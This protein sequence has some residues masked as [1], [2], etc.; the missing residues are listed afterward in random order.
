MDNR[1]I[2]DIGSIISDINLGTA[3]KFGRVFHEKI[4]TQGEEEEHIPQMDMCEDKGPIGDY[5]ST[6]RELSLL[7]DNIK[8]KW[9]I[10]NNTEVD[11]FNTYYQRDLLY[12]YDRISLDMDY[13]NG[14]PERNNG[15]L[16]KL[17]ELKYEIRNLL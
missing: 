10:Y 17:L 8:Q 16:E 6:Y 13:L 11:L 3:S 2:L 4:A 14:N 5:E 9:G 1:N 12:L 15:W 7:L